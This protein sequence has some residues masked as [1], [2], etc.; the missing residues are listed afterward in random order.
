MAG[1]GGGAWKVAYADFV[2][3]MMAFFLVMWI[4][5]QNKPVKEA[6]AAYFKDP[7]GAGK[8]SGSDSPIPMQGDGP[9]PLNRNAVAPK[10]RAAEKKGIR[11]SKSPKPPRVAV[12]GDEGSN[13]GTEVPFADESA[14]LD[15][16]ARQV[17]D[18]IV[19]TLLGKFNKIEVRGHCSGRRLPAD[20][21]YKN[22]WELSYARS[23]ATMH[24]LIEKGV[25]PKR[26]RLSQ[27]AA[28]D[29]R[30]VMANEG[31][32]QNSRVEVYV[33][34]EVVNDPSDPDQ[35]RAER[36]KQR[37]TSASESTVP[38]D[39]PLSRSRS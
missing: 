12:E 29:P 32:L 5:A 38:V 26:M 7:A 3:A 30:Q 8:S 24:Y 23:F 33:L 13:I 4:V 18:D 2:T 19:P 14:E 22:L 16:H 21:P 37:A 10:Q 28:N 35:R 20:A 39:N 15:Q 31:R 34:N 25:D 17:L 36:A 11:T 27:S 1:K 6:V 9:S